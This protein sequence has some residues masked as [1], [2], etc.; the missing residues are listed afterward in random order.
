M[1]S[2]SQSADSPSANRAYWNRLADR[3]QRETRLSITD[4]HY[5]PLLPGDSELRLLPPITPGTRC[6]EVGCGAGQNSICLAARGAAC[7]AIDIAESQLDHGRRL[8][9]GKGLT[10]DFRHLAM[11]A[12]PGALPASF[13]LVHSTYAL[14][15]AEHPDAVIQACAALLRPGGTLLL[16]TAHPLYAGEW[17]AVSDRYGDQ[18]GLFLG[19]YFNPPPDVRDD[20]HGGVSASRPVPVSTT[21]TWIRA[22]GL[23]LD[24]LEEPQPL[25][26][27]RMSAAEIE[28]RVP[29]YS[30]AWAEHLPVL[31][32]IPA[33]AVFRALKPI[34]PA[35]P[36]TPPGQDSAPG[37]PPATAAPPARP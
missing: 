15:F 22:A 2:I 21:V 27:D 16:T 11:E 36:I 17:L 37:S 33:V 34:A 6:L 30:D 7:V 25:P 5:G 29:Y 28:R 4:F 9:S 19:D 13:D 20:D 35:R 1:P 10:V 8:A 14:P 12:L 24:R 3:Y 31:E 18:W 26:V 23:H 32:R